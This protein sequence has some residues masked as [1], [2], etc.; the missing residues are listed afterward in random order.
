MRRRVPGLD[1][2]AAG[3]FTPEDWRLEPPRALAKLRRAM[4]AAGVQ[5]VDAQVVGFKPGSVR[6]GDGGVHGADVLVLSPGA[7]PCD[8]APE[9]AALSPI[10]GQI[11]RY[12]HIRS[13]GE[14]PVIRCQGGYA[15]AARDGL[16]VGATMEPGLAARG[17]DPGLIAP[18]ARWA[19]ELFPDV[20]GASFVADSGIRAATPDGLP[21]VGPSA[22]AGV[23]VAV[24]ARRNGWLL[25]PL[26]ARM[27]AAY[28]ADRDPGPFA[29]VLE[30]RR[31]S[32][33]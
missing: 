32:P 15:V 3:L 5:F 6:L 13:D 21:L 18:M 17:V 2:G 16:A 30:A 20:R 7:D 1:G 23:F 19:A 31:F 8:L 22:A 14:Q 33:A 26:V 4:Q 11:L 27:I 24:G 25:A 9:L 29:G 12:P 28:L 10:K